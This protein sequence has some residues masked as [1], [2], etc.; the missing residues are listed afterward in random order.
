MQLMNFPIKIFVLFAAFLG[1]ILV[2]PGQVKAQS[3]TDSKL[4]QLINLERQKQGLPP[5]NF[6]SKLFQAAKTHNELMNNCANL[7]GKTACFKHQVTQLGELPLMDRIKATGY[8]PKSVGEI[9]GWG[10]K[11][12]EDMVKGWMASTGHRGNILTTE[13][14]DIGCN[15]LNAGSGDYR[16]MWWTCDFGKSFTSQPSSAPIVTSTPTPSPTASPTPTPTPSASP[17]V[18]PRPTVS[19]TPSPITTEKPWW[20]VFFPSSTSCS[21]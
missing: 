7:H 5:L 10:Y 20:C 1:V 13:R 16:K 12:P 14:V 2:F 6:S 4:V 11:T 9:I 17:T 15:F 19:P 21:V 3:V 8:N 18:S